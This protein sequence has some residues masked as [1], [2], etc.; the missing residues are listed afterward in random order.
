MKLRTAAG[1]IWLA[2][3]I[4]PIPNPAAAAGLM[5][6]VAQI[7]AQAAQDQRAVCRGPMR[8]DI[9]TGLPGNPADDIRCQTIASLST[10]CVQLAVATGSFRREVLSGQYSFSRLHSYEDNKSQPEYDFSA[11]EL[12]ESLPPDL[13][14]GALVRAVYAQ[15]MS[16]VR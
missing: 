14:G 11:L 16:V 13:H 15:C 8:N 12:A 7:E 6:A 2:A 9:P 1:A 5:P 3:C 4:A 10:F